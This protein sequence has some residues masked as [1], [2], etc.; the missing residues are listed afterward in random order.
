M[1]RSLRSF[2][3]IFTI[4]RK[5]LW[6]NRWLALAGLSGFLAATALAFALPLYADSVYQRVLDREITENASAIIPPFSFTFN[7]NKWG[8]YAAADAF[9]DQQVPGLVGLPRRKTI[10]YFQT[11]SLRI[12]P[13][14]VVTNDKPGPP[15]GW[16]PIASIGEFADHVTL[17]D[18]HLPAALDGE[19]I[20]A[21]QA[22][23][24][25]EVIVSKSLATALGMY[26]GRDY[27]A[28]SRQDKAV[29]VPFV[30]AGIWEPRDPYDPYL[31]YYQRDVLNKML[32]VA[33][34]TFVRIAQPLR[35]ELFSAQWFMDFDGGAGVR[36]WDVQPFIDRVN[37][38]E[39]QIKA[40]QLDVSL[41]ITPA[42][43]LLA[44]QRESR[45]LAAQLYA[46]S[47]PVFVLVF[48]FI[49]LV[50]GVM[51]NSRRA[52]IA[53]MRSRGA[54]A[55][56]VLG[57][58]LIEACLLAGVAM[59]LAV[60][61]ALGVA[62]AVGQTRS[63]LSF[64][65]DDLLPVVFTA[66]ALPFGWLVAAAAILAAVLPNLESTRHTIISHKLDRARST[67]P[68]WWKRLGLDILLLIPAGYWTYL[69]HRQG[70]VDLPGLGNTSDPFS[71]PSLFLMPALA[72]F[73]L[74]LFYIRWVPLLVRALAWLG[75]RMP[76]TAVVLASRQLARAPGFYTT[77][78]FLL[79]MTL[80]MATYT[81]SV[82]ATLDSFLEQQTRYDVG[83]DARLIKTGEERQASA[84]AGTGSGIST[85]FGSM[86]VSLDD[87][88]SAAGAETEQ[89]AADSGPRYSFLPLSDY[90]KIESVQAVARAGEYPCTVRFA[91]GGDA[92][93]TL[94]GVDRSDF[95]RVA[96]WRR[97][98]AGE[99]LGALMNTLGSQ[100]DG[101]L[102]PESMLSERGLRIGDLIQVK[103]YIGGGTAPLALG[104]VGT[105]KL[106]PTWYPGQSGGMLLVGNLDYLFEV[107]GG[108]YPYDVWMKG[109]PGADPAAIVAQAR[110]ID[111][112]MRR[113]DDVQ[114]L[115]ER[116][117]TRPQRQGL[118]GMLTIGFLSAA[119]FTVLGFT[120]Y[121]VFSLRRRFIELGVLRAIGLSTP[122]L[123]TYLAMEIAL[124]L[125]A[126]L[127]G[128]T[129]LGVLASRLYI[130]FLQAQTA[131][132]LPFQI[133]IDWTQVYLVYAL[134]GL[135]FLIALAALVGYVRRLRI[136][137]AVKL[138]ET[139]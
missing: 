36:V 42:D 53:V 54:T 60:P 34:D 94:L 56:Q 30:V 19:A 23:P 130:P 133:V 13:S 67:A 51:A 106:W 112:Q 59:A 62:Q 109:K 111:K 44:Y 88:G 83:G 96:F 35:R 17:I 70:T 101:V 33:E 114:T 2:L 31:A 80:A 113:A 73:A 120:L 25:I 3:A 48:A 41:G 16:S 103:V 97:D 10:R 68:P 128:G 81:A 118:F 64:A 43:R 99:S 91:M 47:V 39:A 12:Y 87:S 100:M 78:V 116:E 131:R 71:N 49:L 72:I 139:E 57:I 9:M 63:F 110:A 14:E 132:S 77:P 69:L 124:L 107:V 76:G 86:T 93:C 125:G 92:S 18:G 15:L 37:R 138:G 117:H 105:F 24:R 82:A 27:V 1:G 89:A 6:A 121:A 134:F 136:F 38:M 127:L 75:S 50:T 5:R 11:N 52:E 8:D 108:Q 61:A 102:V 55:W 45:Q 98:F 115:V 126:G 123:A 84:W 4:A 40:Q 90:L 7:Y 32:Y 137:Q 104:V 95:A 29:K 65:Q 66:A 21:G 119:L 129:S 28:L 22:V 85:S 46:F 26:V 20:R 74:T 79:T 58:T 135:I 122:Q